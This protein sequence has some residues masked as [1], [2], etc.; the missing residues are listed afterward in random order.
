MENCFAETR[1]GDKPRLRRM[2][3]YKLRR[4]AVRRLRP[5]F[6]LNRKALLEGE[7]GPDTSAV[8]GEAFGRNVCNP[9]ITRLSI[10]GP[11]QA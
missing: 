7:I 5:Q 1:G 9:S 10:S 11:V 4:R 2:E 6:G 3:K 8:V